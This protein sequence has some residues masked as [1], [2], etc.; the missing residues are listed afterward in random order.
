MVTTLALLERDRGSVGPSREFMKM[1]LMISGARRCMAGSEPFMRLL[2]LCR[3]S[4]IG[5]GELDVVVEVRKPKA[6]NGKGAL[7]MMI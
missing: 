2:L 3:S 7:I 1:M 5:R 6:T 4:A